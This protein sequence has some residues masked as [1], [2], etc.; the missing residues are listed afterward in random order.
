MYDSC[1]I[2]NSHVDPDAGSCPSCGFKLG[3]STQKLDPISI[4]A[5]IKRPEDHKVKEASFIVIRGEQINSVYKLENRRMSIGRSP[6]NDI[7]LN[8]MT[9]SSIHADVFVRDGRYI[10]K[11]NGS[12]NGVWINNENIDE[13]PLHDGDIVQIGVFC[14]LFEQ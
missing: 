10:I 11:D 9:V 5:P 12:F 1:P 8:D 2:C 7:F 6:R 14:L 4:G 3:G 13:A